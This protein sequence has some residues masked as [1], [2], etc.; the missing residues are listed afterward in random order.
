MLYKKLLLIPLTLLSLSTFSLATVYSDGEDG[1]VDTWSVYDNSPEGATISNVSDETRTSNVIEFQGEGRSNAYLLGK[2][3]WNNRSEHYLKWSMN[4]SERFKLSLYLTTAHGSRTLY[5]D[6][7][8]YD[9]GFYHQKYIKI[10]LGSKSMSGTWQSFTR[11]VEADLKQYDPSN[12]LVAI[13]G[14]KVQGSGRIDDVRLEKEGETSTPPPSGGTEL[15]EDAE[16]GTTDGW[17]VVDNTP[18]G[19]TIRNIVDRDHG[20][21]IQLKGEGRANAYLFGEKTSSLKSDKQTLSW[22]MKIKEKYKITV[23]TSTQKGLRSFVLTHSNSNKGLYRGKYIYLGLKA[24]SM[25]GSWQKFS[26]DLAYE[27]S[28]YEPDNKLLRIN[29]FKVQGSGLF[30]NILVSS[31]TV[32]TPPTPS[33]GKDA[34]VATWEIGKEKS[35]Q[36]GTVSNYQYNFNIDWGD[37]TSNANVTNTILHNYEKEGNYTVAITGT[38]PW[39]VY[40][41]YRDV[42]QDGIRIGYQ[43]L[44][45]LEQWGTQKWKSMHS[46]FAICK[47]FN[48]IND[49]KAPD[50]SNVDSMGYM[51]DKATI[52]NQPIGHWDVS[53]VTDMD[54][55][56]YGV[57]AYNQDLSAWDVSKVTYMTGGTALSMENYDK[58]LI[59]WSQLKLQQN[60]FL[61]N[62]S[63]Y[64][65]HAANARQLLIDK[66]NWRIYDEG[67]AP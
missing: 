65:S 19:A 54:S 48:I 2:K 31:D 64:S 67:E 1:T 11:D 15:N 37:G 17:T 25:N 42:N 23:Y 32:V 26:F 22:A 29:G 9:K 16:D 10:G 40:L 14:F 4:F 8:S 56:F 47:D 53:N 33:Y 43:K 44:I 45:A 50:L 52:F 36:I 41:C 39:A 28:K 35:L 21:V 49:P 27:L 63:H 18:S 20:H 61:G 5:Y 59:A 51:F 12:S 13:K 30:D 38:Y 3:D 6:Y 60:V 66:F 7:K 46:V 24:E 58:L 57:Q 34:F 55:M 62:R